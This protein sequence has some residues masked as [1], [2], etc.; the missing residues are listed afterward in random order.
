LRTTAFGLPGISVVSWYRNWNLRHFDSSGPL[1]LSPSDPFQINFWQGR[2]IFLYQKS[3][4]SMYRMFRLNERFVFLN[5]RTIFF[6]H[7]II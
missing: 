4:H 1:A 5:I 3:K 2:G 7:D 6:L